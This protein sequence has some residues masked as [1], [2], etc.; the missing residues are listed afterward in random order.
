[1][2]I[3]DILAGGPWA[4]AVMIGYAVWRGDLRLRRE[5][6]GETLR[7][8]RLEAE[9]EALAQ[10]L[11]AVTAAAQQALREEQES[12]RRELSELRKT[13]ALMVKTVAGKVQ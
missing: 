2:T 12:T 7:C 5:V 11:R 4:L 13:N 8:T 6:E 3:A 9:K 1:M 10:E